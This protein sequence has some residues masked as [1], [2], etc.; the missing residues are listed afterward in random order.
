MF[1]CSDE[2]TVDALWKS[3]NEM[4]GIST[5]V[6]TSLQRRKRAGNGRS[7]QSSQVGKHLH[8][9][10]GCCT[11]SPQG[12]RSSWARNHCPPGP[13]SLHVAVYPYPLSYPFRNWSSCLPA[14][15]KPFSKELNPRR[16]SGASQELQLTQTDVVGNLGTYHCNWHLRGVGRVWWD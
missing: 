13:V 5:P 1:S 16:R 2:I 15:S 3:H 10:G 6:S 4:L 12:R 11:P 9:T 7:L 8:R 14:F